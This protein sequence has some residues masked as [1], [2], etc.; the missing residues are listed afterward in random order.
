MKYK[1]Q[2]ASVNGW[3]DLKFTVRDHPH[4]T[5]AIEE[6]ASKKEATQEITDIVIATDGNFSEYRAVPIDTPQDDELYVGWCVVGAH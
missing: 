5:Y 4:P 1:I 6:F 2:T 3:A